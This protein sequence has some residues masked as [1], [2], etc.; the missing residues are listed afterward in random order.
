MRPLCGQHCA[1]LHEYTGDVGSGGAAQ[2]GDPLVLRRN[3]LLQLLRRFFREGQSQHITSVREVGE[4]AYRTISRNIG[5][6]PRCRGRE[7]TW[8]C[9][10]TRDL[11]FLFSHV[12]LQRAHLGLHPGQLLVHGLQCVLPLP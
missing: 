4:Q 12:T 2:F 10:G 5:E 9:L 8:Q 11:L 7:G 1:I 6:Q 3:R